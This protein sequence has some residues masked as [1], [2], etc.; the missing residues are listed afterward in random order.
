MSSVVSEGNKNIGLLEPCFFFCWASDNSRFIVDLLICLMELII[1][2]LDCGLWRL[3]KLFVF[4]SHLP[5]LIFVVA[6]I[7]PWREDSVVDCCQEI[8]F[9]RGRHW[10]DKKTVCNC[11]LKKF[12]VPCSLQVV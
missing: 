4:L 12:L 9:S 2:H 1:F 10:K 6:L 11:C 7:L 8:W 5:E 3:S